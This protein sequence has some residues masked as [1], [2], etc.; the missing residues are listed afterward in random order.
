MANRDAFD[1]FAGLDSLTAG[2]LQWYE[3]LTDEGRKAAAPFVIQRW[4]TGTQDAAQVVRLNTFVN[5]YAFSLGQEK[6]LLF[7]LLAAAT[8]H[9][10][11]RYSWL[12]GPSA[13]SNRLALEVVKEYYGWST[14]E[15]ELQPM[16]PELLLEMA[17]ELGWDNDRLKKLKNEVLPDEPKRATQPGRQPS[18][19]R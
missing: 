12:K 4:L 3:Q 7:K 15:A 17:E 13:T 6:A 8:T 2:N 14:R 11:K 10:P 18:K 16:A 19:P 9:R 1:L 5:P